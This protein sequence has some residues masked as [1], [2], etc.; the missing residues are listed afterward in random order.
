MLLVSLLLPRKTMRS[1]T[2]IFN[3]NDPG[4]GRGQGGGGNE[5]PRRPPQ[6]NGPPDLDQ[7]WRDFNN[8]LGGLFGGKRGGGKNGGPLSSGGP[9]PRQSKIGLG[10]IVAVST[11]F[12]N[13]KSTAQAGFQWRIP[14]PIQSHE[15]VNLSQLRTFEVGFR[16][17]ARNRV[18]PESLMLTD[19]EN[20]VDV[21]FV[22]QY[23]LR[24]DG[25]PDY[26]FKTKDPDESVRQ[27]SQSAMRE[28]VGTRSMDFVLYEGRTAVAAEVQK[29]MQQILDRYQTG[30]QVSSVAIQNVQPPEPVQAAFD[31]A[32]KAGQD[33]ERQ[34]NEGQAYRNQIVPLAAGQSSR[35]LE[36]AEGYRARV[37]GNAVGDAAR[38][39]SVLGEYRKAPE[40]LRER[41]YLETMQQMYSNAS[42]IL[43]DTSGSNNM[44][45]LP[46]DKITQQA[47]QGAQRINPMA[48]TPV[49]TNAP[50][51]LTQTS[52]L[53]R[54]AAPGPINTLTRDRGSR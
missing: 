49:Q 4:W 5:P 2:K 15:M 1:L 31:D 23:R 33:R 51:P 14:A 40:V 6:G 42:K 11:Q 44:L 54:P 35:M 41:M 46:L 24:A 26:L 3:L 34:I 32:V 43:V 50:N 29:Q 52:P 7:V 48:N 53:T 37:V 36:Q 10:V 30:I 22:V 12:G 20:I 45:Y 38:F 21:Q 17:N 28:V 18:L 27:A 16:G 9:S 39:T 13:Y 25:A 8:R 19:D 47:A